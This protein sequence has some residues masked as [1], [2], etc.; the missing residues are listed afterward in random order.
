MQL[1]DIND[2]PEGMDKKHVSPITFAEF[3]YINIYKG[4][5]K[6]PCTVTRYP[7][8]GLGSVYPSLVYLKST[9]QADILEELDE[10]GI[11]TGDIAYQFPRRGISFMN[12][13]APHPSHLARLGADFDG[14]TISFTALLTEEAKQ[15]IYNLLHSARFYV[16]TDRRMTY[17]VSDD[18]ADIT[19]DYMTG[20]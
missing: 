17:S 4:A 9:V 18:I 6:I 13:V 14:D 15:E 5:D 12:T 20:D 3:L 10:H 1:H 2:L 11:P 16:N 19:L 8:T 7:I